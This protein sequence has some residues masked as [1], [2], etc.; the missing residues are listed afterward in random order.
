LAR[1]HDF[2]KLT[3]LHAMNDLS[4]CLNCALR[5]QLYNTSMCVSNLVML[6][7]EHAPI[8]LGLHVGLTHIYADEGLPPCVRG[9]VGSAHWSILPHPE[10][11][12][13]GAVPMDIAT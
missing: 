4:P 6:T 2:K 5:C 12:H 8:T 11:P 1:P 13:S 10:N 9:S 3:S 7:D